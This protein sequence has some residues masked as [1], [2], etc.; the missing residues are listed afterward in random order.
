MTKTFVEGALSF[1]ADAQKQNKPFYLNLWPD[2]M[3]TP[4]D[5]PEGMPRDTKKA[6]YASVLQNM[7]AQ[8]AP[9]FDAAHHAT[10]VDR[11]VSRLDVLYPPREDVLELHV[12]AFNESIVALLVDVVAG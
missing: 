4:L 11:P 2:D 3:H 6:R 9:L 12:M 1:I 5:P 8:L 10:G 7:D